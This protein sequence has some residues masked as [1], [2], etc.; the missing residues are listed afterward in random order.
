[1]KFSFNVGAEEIHHV[2]FQWDRV[3]GGPVRIF[4]DGVLIVKDW[5]FGF[6]F[7]L[8]PV[9]C[10]QFVVGTGEQHH[11]TIEKQNRY[12]LSKST[13]RRYRVLIDGQLFQE[14][15]GF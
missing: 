15:D 12:F 2:H 1:M 10:W 4:V 5:M 11:V 13:N 3:W 8:K 7:T 9:R 6:N 14:Y